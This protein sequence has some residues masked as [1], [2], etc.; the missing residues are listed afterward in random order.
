LVFASITSWESIVVAEV[1]GVDP[2]IAVLEDHVDGI[3]V[4]TSGVAVGE[5][6][7]GVPD[8]CG[9]VSE[10]VIMGKVVTENEGG[11]GG[12]L[13]ENVDSWTGGILE[14]ITDGITDN[15]SDVLLSELE[16][17]LH[18][19]LV[20]FVESLLIEAFSLDVESVGTDFSSV[21]VGEEFVVLDLHEGK[22]DTFA[23]GLLSELRSVGLD[24]FLG[25]IPSTTGV[26]LGDSNLDTGNDGTS[27]DTS[28]GVWTEDESSEEWGTNNENTWGD[29]LLE[30]SLGGDLD[31]TFIVWLISSSSSSGFLSLIVILDDEVHHVIGG[32]SDSLHGEGGEEVWEHSTDKETG[33]LGW[34]ED[35]N[36]GITDSGNESTEEGKTDE[37]GRSDS[38]TFTDSGG[39]VSCGIKGI[40][41]ISDLSW[42]S[43]HLSASSGIV[44]DW[45]VSINGKGDWEGSEHTEGGETN[46]VHTGVGETVSNGGGDADNWDNDGNVT[47]G[48]TE[49]NVWCWTFVA[50]ISEPFGWGV[51]VVG[52]VF[53]DETDDHT[54]PES[55]HDATVSSPSVHGE[56]D[57]LG[58]S[59]EGEGFW[60]DEDG[61]DDAT[62]HDDGGSTNLELKDRL[63]V[64]SLDSSGVSEED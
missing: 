23:F 42:E 3:W 28:G 15:S 59:F 35:I 62:G 32:I 27:K 46:T 29:H 17:S 33:E 50:S 22:V 25:V 30:G 38:E 40:S 1:S 63:N 14:W 13:D 4:L 34:L 9:G 57:L 51:G 56:W 47:E 19:F 5:E 64:L 16:V 12:K 49:D 18:P 36:G 53:S 37:A 2:G 52:V 26:G 58:S 6:L 45:A 54:G 48:E 43:G 55:E 60:E 11:N 61:W 8:W 31:A 44:G 21:S 39:G 24:L 41:K 20:E 7:P 10:E